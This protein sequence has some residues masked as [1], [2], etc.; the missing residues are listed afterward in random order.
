MCRLRERKLNVLQAVL[1]AF[2][3]PEDLIL[4]ATG[5]CGNETMGASCGPS[6][7]YIEDIGQCRSLIQP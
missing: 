5:K 7:E 1:P 4:Q 2:E 6:Y 3:C